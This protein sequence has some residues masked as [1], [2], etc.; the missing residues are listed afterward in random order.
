MSGIHTLLLRHPRWCG[1]SELDGP[2][3]PRSDPRPSDFQLPF[4]VGIG[5]LIWDQWTSNARHE[6]CAGHVTLMHWTMNSA[7]TQMFMW[8]KKGECLSACCKNGRE[9]IIKFSNCTFSR[10]KRLSRCRG[11][12]FPVV[13]VLSILPR[14]RGGQL[15]N[16]LAAS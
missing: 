16:C 11:Q 15:L 1:G 3:S 9:L 7:S 6:F 10:F 2:L 5:G 13:C 12:I 4:R 8:W 14:S